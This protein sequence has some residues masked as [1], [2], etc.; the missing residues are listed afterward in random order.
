MTEGLRI[1]VVAGEASGDQLGAGLLRA[2]RQRLP[3][4][5]FEGVGGPLMTAEGC[6]SLAPF[7]MLSVMGITE[8]AGRLFELLRIRRDLARR[9]LANPPDLFI[10]IDSPGFNLGL[11]GR[12]KRAGIP[13]VQYVS[14]QVW[15]WRSYRA[16]KIRRAVDRV[17]T[18]F[19]FESTF[20]KQHKVSATFVGHPLADEIAGAVD[21]PALRKKLH[22]SQDKT[23]IALL[24]GSRV[25]ELKAHADLFVRTA[26]WL[27]ARNQNLH[28]VAPF[29]NRRT[30]LI[31]EEAVKHHGAWDLPITRLHGHSRQAM[32]AADIALLAS[33]TAALE[34]MLLGRPMVVTYKVSWLSSWL[35]KSFAHVKFFSMPN[36]L[37]GRPL[38]PE[39]LQ[40]AAH[41]GILGQAIERGLQATAETEKTL[42]TFENLA[43]TLRR[44]A[45]ERAAKAVLAVLR[46]AGKLKKTVRRAA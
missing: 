6:Q 32:G 20:Y 7:E 25:S 37:A 31:F 2:L 15:A 17:L 16:H 13:T 28:F 1:A 19:P 9:F 3:G 41:P 12:L 42:Q 44:G 8:V 4:V 11:A 39:Y 43:K 21:R 5:R 22:L 29:V 18:L 27:Y 38:V 26:L 24:P 46:R 23:V 35:I 45:N 33:G 14:P 10:G 40:R 34:A 30:R 36:H